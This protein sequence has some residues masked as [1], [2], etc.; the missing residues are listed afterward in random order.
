[1]EPTERKWVAPNT[2]RKSVL[3]YRVSQV[4][5]LQVRRVSHFPLCAVLN[6]PWGKLAAHGLPYPI[7]IV[8][9]SC[10]GDNAHHDSR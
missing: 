3:R 10:M 5:I 2:S 9:H 7:V 4:V 8:T 6:E 1:M